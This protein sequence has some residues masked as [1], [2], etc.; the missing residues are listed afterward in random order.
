MAFNLHG[1]NLVG[2]A[3]NSLVRRSTSLEGR[4]YGTY[5]VALSRTNSWL[6]TTFDLVWE[7]HREFGI[8][9]QLLCDISEGGMMKNPC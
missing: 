4:M 5:W 7:L 1:E 6:V 8:D 9:D 3:A 2:L